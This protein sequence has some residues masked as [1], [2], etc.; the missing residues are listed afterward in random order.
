MGKDAA[1]EKKP[2]ID[3]HCHIVALGPASGAILHRRTKNHYIYRSMLVA[4]GYIGGITDDEFDRRYVRRL[5]RMLAESETTEMAVVL[6]I[7][8]IYDSRGR[9]DDARTQVYVPND[10][11]SRI[12]GGHDDFLFGASVNPARAD[13]LDELER[14]AQMGA[15][16][17]KWVPNSQDFDPASRRF[18]K[19]YSRMADLGLPLLSHTGYEHCIPATD[20]MYGDPARLERA[21]DA[22]VT[23]IAG[24]AGCSG[25]L[26]PVEFF[27]GYL[28][29]LER[30]PN[31]YGDLSA[32][33]GLSRFGYIRRMLR[34]PGFFDR[35]IQA[36]DYP[37]PPWP[38]LF[39]GRLAPREIVRLMRIGNIF[40]R[41]VYTKQ[42][43]GV[44]ESTLYVAGDVLSGALSIHD[45]RRAPDGAK[46]TAPA[47]APRRRN[48]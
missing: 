42:A 14:V 44:P 39:A 34:K 3:A 48:R 26:H 11:V 19:F 4:Q 32:L 22:G 7:D 33:C 23:V 9:L 36:T 18:D 46:A 21:L 13:A 35:H 2:V 10:Y 8:G 43:L 6:A 47:A 12:A 16:L 5:A 27:D 45:S 15:A 20:Q 30:H 24:H 38:F 25:H 29:M 37:V 1:S 40:D 17:V 31:L 41:D 28:R